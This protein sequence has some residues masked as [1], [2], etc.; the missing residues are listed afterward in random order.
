MLRVENES[1]FTDYERAQVDSPI[2]RKVISEERTIYASRPFRQPH[3]HAYG[4]PVLCDFG[5]SRIGGSHAYAEIQP[6]VYKSPEILMQMDW[7]H[8]ADIWNA[9]CVVS[10]IIVVDYTSPH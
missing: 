2:H 4:L 1:I 6:E 10:L 5:E 9:A 7:G 3:E 8:P